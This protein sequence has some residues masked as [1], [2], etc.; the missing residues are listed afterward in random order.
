MYSATAI[1]VNQQQRDCT[2][3]TRRAGA[4]APALRDY[5]AATTRLHTRER[6]AQAYMRYGPDAG[7]S[8]TTGL[9]IRGRGARTSETWPRFERIS[10]HRTTHP[11]TRAP[12]LQG[13]AAI[14]ANRQPQDCTSMG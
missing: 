9:H 12:G 10:S 8:A 11:A 6:G 14:R 5:E 4:H 3:P 7:E 2:S 13:L 1:C